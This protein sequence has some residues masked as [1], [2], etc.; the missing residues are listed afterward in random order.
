MIS[1]SHSRGKG[2]YAFLAL[3]LLLTFFL[4]TPLP[5]TQRTVLIEEWE[6]TS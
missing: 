5:A 3:P 6:N 2:L 1:S 4:S